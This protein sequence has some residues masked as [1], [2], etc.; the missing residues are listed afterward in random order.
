MTSPVEGEMSGGNSV[1]RRRDR[2]RRGTKRRGS[3]SNRAERKRLALVSAAPG[4]LGSRVSNG[5]I[6]RATKA[7]NRYQSFSQSMVVRLAKKRRALVSVAKDCRKKCSFCNECDRCSHRHRLRVSYRDQRSRWLNM[8]S[9]RSGDPRDFCVL[10]L[11][12]LL[13]GVEGFLEQTLGVVTERDWLEYQGVAESTLDPAS[14][15][16]PLETHQT[17]SHMIRSGRIQ[18]TREPSVVG[19][20]RPYRGRPRRPTV[21]QGRGRPCRSCGNY[22]GLPVAECQRSEA[23]RRLVERSHLAASRRRR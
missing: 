8:A 13:L 3:R 4:K 15:G 1:S 7:F 23:N 5:G 17:V 10:R 22:C 12:A 14:S 21:T 11:T 19:S 16:A 20:Y 6:G 2:S 18:L 9:H